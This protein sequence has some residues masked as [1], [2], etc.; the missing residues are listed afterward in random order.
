M[1]RDNFLQNNLESSALF[2][3]LETTL[4]TIFSLTSIAL[5]GKWKHV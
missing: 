2:N 4:F 5:S 1:I 3:A